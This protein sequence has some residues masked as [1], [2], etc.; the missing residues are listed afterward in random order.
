MVDKELMLPSK[1]LELA[2]GIVE[3]RSCDTQPWRFLSRLL[4]EAAATAQTGPSRADLSRMLHAWWSPRHDWW[5]EAC[6]QVRGHIDGGVDLWTE[7]AACASALVR[8]LRA[9]Y[10]GDR[11]EVDSLLALTEQAL[12]PLLGPPFSS[13]PVE[14]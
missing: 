1:A 14:V 3:I 2:A 4:R 11:A 9:A 5:P 8:A 6:F 10:G 13:Q 7:R 12:A